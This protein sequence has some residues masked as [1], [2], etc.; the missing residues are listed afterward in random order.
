MCDSNFYEVMSPEVVEFENY[1]FL[2]LCYHKAG[3]DFPA[4]SKIVTFSPDDIMVFT[5]L[6]INDDNI[7]L[8]GE[9]QFIVAVTSAEPNILIGEINTSRITI[10]DDDRKSVYSFYDSNYL[11]SSP[12][13]LPISYCWKSNLENSAGMMGES[14]L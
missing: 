14:D 10:L 9:E 2:I 6:M 8:E 4:V 13:C 1:N 11:Y 7:T 5:T 12:Y 3:E